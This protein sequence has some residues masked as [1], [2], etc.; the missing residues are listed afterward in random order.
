MTFTLPIA[1]L[2]LASVPLLVAVYFLRSRFRRREVSSLFLWLDQR[3]PREGGRRFE[4]LRT[5]FLFLLE[6]LALVL[7]AVAAA[8]PYLPLG[9]RGS[10]LAVVLDDSYSMLSGATDSPRSR[11]LEALHECLDDERGPNVRLVLAASRPRLLGGAVRSSREIEEL[12]DHWTCRAPGAAIEEAVALATAAVGAQGRV[13]VLSDRPPPDGFS[14]DRVEW[15]AFGRAL[16]NLAIVNAARSRREGGERVLVEAANLSGASSAATLVISA[17]GKALLEQDLMLSA[18]ETRRLPLDLGAVEAPLDLSLHA[19]SPS[20]DALADDSSAVLVP[21]ERRELGVELRLAGAGLRASVEK[22]LKAA[23]RAR[24][25]ARGDL[26]VTDEPA[27]AGAGAD[28]GAGAGA[29]WILR[30]VVD[31][32][33]RPLVGPFILDRSHPLA[34]GL[35]LEG[36]VWG[37]GEGDLDGHPIIAAGTTPLL[38]ES[39]GPGGSRELKLRLAPDQSTIERS[40]AWPVLFANLLDWRAAALPGLARPQLRLGEDAVLV[41]EPGVESV[42]LVEPDGTELELDVRDS[43]AVHAADKA[44]LH[45]FD[46][47]GRRHILA[48]NAFHRG[49]SDLRRAS[50]GAW[51]SWIEDPGLRA[52]AE[53]LAWVFGVLAL[54]VLA[55]HGVMARLGSASTITSTSTS[56]MASGRSEL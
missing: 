21:P 1:L 20:A 4:R 39:A 12:L 31:A 5:P 3:R 36:V 43:R 50:S 42:G 23:G 49:E 54:A 7:L 52:D 45:V 15:R 16:P 46:A 22:A 13:L 37:A 51:G 40:V 41:V 29:P 10:P 11:A 6:L 38:V 44:G 19:A 17:A 35:T 25:G 56:T 27:G 18:G 28:P 14:G 8:R 48:A 9:G 30:F 47:A 24:L 2:G 34:A 55:V 32:E 53:S 26:V 33:G